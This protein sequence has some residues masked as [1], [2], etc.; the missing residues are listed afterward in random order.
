MLALHRGPGKMN[1]STRY[2]FFRVAA[3]CPRA[4]IADPARNVTEILDLVAEARGK[5]VQ[6]LITPE[7]GITSYTAADLFFQQTT[8]LK[9]A[10]AGL[11]R[12][13]A[14]TR[15][16]DMTLAVGLPLARDS[17]LWNA[18]AIVQKGRVR[19]V[20]LKSFIPNYKEFYEGRWFSPA[21][22]AVRD[23]IE[24]LG[25]R[26]PAGADLV[27]RVDGEESLALG[28]E[29]CEDLWVPSPPEC[30]P[31]PGRSH[32]PRQPVRFERGHRK[33]GIPAG[34]GQAA[35]RADAL[36][37]RLLE[38]GGARIDHRPGFRRAP[39]GGGERRDAGREPTVP[40]GSG[41]DCHG[42]RCR[43][44]LGG[45]VAAE[46]ILGNG[47]NAAAYPVGDP[48]PDGPAE[49]HA[50][51]ARHRAPSLCPGRRRR[52]G[53]TL[54]RDLRNPD[55]GSGPPV[56]AHRRAESSSSAFPGGSIRLSPSSWPAG[57]AG[58]SAGP[59]SPSS[60]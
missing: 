31:R 19:G 3:G 59:E 55:R 16:L 60:P 27:F 43:T 5:G 2:G 40:A 28:F 23:D 33:G 54:Q 17:R 24:I 14:R 15:H 44:A 21:R 20:V 47:G 50:A 32:H 49:I 48:G 46:D 1:G 13:C 7:L 56:G 57:P 29:I 37:L 52:S 25:A 42:G 9:A 45:A 18:A 11:Q 4:H 38:C 30:A 6:L 34:A 12:L 39:D 53:Q 26:V 22:E 10:E 41:T 8:L 51:A 58:C 36:G 35:Q